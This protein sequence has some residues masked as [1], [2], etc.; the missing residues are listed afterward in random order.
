[1]NVYYYTIIL[2]MYYT[3]EVNI[4]GVGNGFTFTRTCIEPLHRITSFFQ[5]WVRTKE[6]EI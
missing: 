3:Y 6:K 4:I 5:A 1:M 2:D